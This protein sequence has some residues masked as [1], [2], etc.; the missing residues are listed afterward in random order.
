MKHERSCLLRQ[1]KFLFV[2]LFSSCSLLEIL[3]EGFISIK[4]PTGFVGKSDKGSP[5]KTKEKQLE[6]YLN[7]N[8]IDKLCSSPTWFSP[9]ARR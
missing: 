7:Y 6:Y 5:F 8:R 3:K 2:F 1:L 4:I 9:K